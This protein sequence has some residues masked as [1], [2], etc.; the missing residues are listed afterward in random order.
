MLRGANHTTGFRI[1]AVDGEI[2]KAADW[3]FDDRTWAVRYLVVDTG[4]WLPGQLVLLAPAAVAAIDDDKKA[5]EV[6]LTREQIE[7]S[8]PAQT[9]Q[10][11][12]RQY[13]MELQRHYGWPAYWAPAGGLGGPAP[14]DALGPALVPSDTAGLEPADTAGESRGDP[15]L[16]SAA[17]VSGYSIDATDGSIGDVQDLIVDDEDWRISYVL[18]D[19][20]PW[21]PGG[22]VLVDTGKVRSV[23]WTDRAVFVNLTREQVRHS[24]PPYDESHPMNR[25]LQRKLYESHRG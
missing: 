9:D 10:P 11:V 5:V 6:G 7:G 14:V 12:S 22:H 18:V 19:T 17:E 4:N 21:W 24:P 3:Y 1:R 15:H 25:E 8:P 16:R 13:E 20:K 23:S 2:G